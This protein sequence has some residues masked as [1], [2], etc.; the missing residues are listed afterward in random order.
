MKKN[1]SLLAAL[2]A[3]KVVTQTLFKKMPVL[4]LVVVYLVDLGIRGYLAAGFSTTYL[5]G[6][7]IL[8]LSIG[9]YVSTRVFQKQR[10]ALYWGC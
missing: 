2:S 1:N 6:M 7:L 4:F 5:L 9:I 8:T 10:L 3:L